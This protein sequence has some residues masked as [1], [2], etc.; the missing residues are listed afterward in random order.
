MEYIKVELPDK[1]H[2]G[3][4]RI[5]DFYKDTMYGPNGEITIVEVWGRD[6]KKVFD[7]FE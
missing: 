7:F 6:G 1:N 4:F 3:G 2:P 5:A